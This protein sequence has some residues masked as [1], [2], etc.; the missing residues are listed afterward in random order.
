MSEPWLR[1]LLVLGT[2]ALVALLAWLGSRRQL[3]RPQMVMRSDLSPGVHFF[4]SETCHPC[5]RA[6]RLLQRMVPSHSEIRFEDDPS[7]FAKFSIAKVPTV[8]VVGEEGQATVFEGIPKRRDLEK[9]VGGR[10]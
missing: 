5:I 8:I 4:S 3:A 2:A 9:V 7:G 1:L 6:R 10:W